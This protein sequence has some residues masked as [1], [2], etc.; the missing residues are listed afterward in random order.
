M[1]GTYC[2]GEGGSGSWA[3][4]E[5]GTPNTFLDATYNS[6]QIGT[7]YWMC[8]TSDACIDA[9]CSASVPTE[10]CSAYGGSIGQCHAI[11]ITNTDST[12]D[13]FGHPFPYDVDWTTV[14]VACN[15]GSGWTAY[16]SPTAANTANVLSNIYWGWDGSNYGSST[17][18]NLESQTA[19][20]VYTGTNASACTGGLKLLI[21]Q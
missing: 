7:A 9:S 15:N 1:S 19:Y 11:D 16:A 17:T 3:V 5:A 12:F 2:D 14:E 13:T 21:Y 10:D 8:L 6:L 4:W 20:W 18:G